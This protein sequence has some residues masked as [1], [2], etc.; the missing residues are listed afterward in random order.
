MYLRTGLRLGLAEVVSIVGGGGKTTLMFKL[1]EEIVAT[2]GQVVTTTTTRIFGAQTSI[3]PVHLVAEHT[4]EFLSELKLMMEEHPHILVTGPVNGT[5]DKAYGISPE[6]VNDIF[7]VGADSNLTVIV[8]ADGSRMRSLKA[9]AE[10][11]PVI[12][13]CTTT[14]VPVVGADVFGQ[15][16]NDKNV[17]R[18]GLVADILGIGYDSRVTSEVV[19]RLLLHQLGGMKN[20]PD[21]SRWLPF[22]NKGASQAQTRFAADTAQILLKEGARDVLV[23]ALLGEDSTVKRYS[24][25]AAVVL[26]A[27]GS[28]RM[29]KDMDIKQMLPWGKGTLVTSVSDAAIQSKVDTIKVVIGNQ[30]DRVGAALTG[31]NVDVVCNTEWTH[32]QS[33]SVRIG[34]ES[35]DDNISG[36]IF[37][38]VDQPN[39]GPAVINAIVDRFHETGAPIVA[40]R[41]AGKKANPVLFDRNLWPE[42]H[43][44]DGDKGGRELISRYYDEVAWVDW[45]DD[46][47]SEINTPDDYNSIGGSFN[48]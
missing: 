4:D 11:E 8:E 20:I 40:A 35:L 15:F 3:A 9:P 26:A 43:M 32:G 44:I 33:G 10:H 31:M 47:L 12:P 28:T 41:V 25:T 39:V 38:L 46:I 6:F 13:R 37:L 29:G 17:H 18:S 2:G 1:A 14:V 22:I 30:A 24:N 7:V 19:A 36:A 5:S 16:L 23:G 27:G 42:L 21:D 48:N 45:N 34:L